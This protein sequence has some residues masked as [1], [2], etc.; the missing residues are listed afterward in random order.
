MLLGTRLLMSLCFLSS[1]KIVQ[2]ATVS[3]TWSS[4]LLKQWTP[5]FFLL[6]KILILWFYQ[7]RVGS[8]RLGWEHTSSE[9]QRKNPANPSPQNQCPLSWSPRKLTTQCPFLLLPVCLSI[10]APNFILVSMAFPNNPEVDGSGCVMWCRLTWCF[11]EVDT[12]CLEKV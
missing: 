10:Y 12:W 3:I 7:W 2:R 4:S 11:A 5:G 8:Q 6:N 1:L 9:R